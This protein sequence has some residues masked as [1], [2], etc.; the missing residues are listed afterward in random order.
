[1]KIL[2]KGRGQVGWTTKAKCTGAGNGNGG[3]G[4]HLLVE[5]GDLFKSYSHA[6]DEMTIYV[7]FRCIECG[8]MTDLA[9]NEGNRAG[10]PGYVWNSVVKGVKHPDGGYC[11][12]KD[13]TTRLGE[14]NV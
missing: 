2:K 14:S 10:V 11:H 9:D 7:T 8:V 5:Q 13:K 1:M 3:C 12:P 4:A 6:R